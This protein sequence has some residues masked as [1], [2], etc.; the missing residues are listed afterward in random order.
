MPSPSVTI[1]IGAEE[2]AARASDAVDSASAARR[3]GNR[4]CARTRPSLTMVRRGNRS[5]LARLR[6]RA[7]QR[8]MTDGEEIVAGPVGREMK[9]EPTDTA[10]NAT[11]DFEQVE[12]DRPDRRRRQARAGEDRAAEIGEQQEREAMELQPEG[13]RAEAMTAEAIRVDI[14]LELFDP[15]LGR[16]AV[17]VPRDEIGGTPAA[18]RDHEAQIEPLCSDIDLDEDAPR[19]RPRFGAVPKAG[20]DVNGLLTATVPRLRLGHESRHA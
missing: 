1:A 17:V 13:V 5:R 11:G 6:G 10:N 2:T 19:V 14:E 18:I 8:A 3:R 7:R 20:P 4:A 16:P 9:P 12:T 15:I